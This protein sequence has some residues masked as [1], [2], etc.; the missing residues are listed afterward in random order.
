VNRMPETRSEMLKA[1]YKCLNSRATCPRC[2]APIEWWES[3]RGIKLPF[4]PPPAG[5]RYPQEEIAQL[6]PRDC[7]PASRPALHQLRPEERKGKVQQIA[8]QLGARVVLVLDDE[9]F[10]YANR[11]GLDAEDVKQDLISAANYISRE[12]GAR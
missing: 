10:S 6:H 7:Q 12:M 1:R 8:E 5:V 11:P 9:G 4:D 2:S 3:T